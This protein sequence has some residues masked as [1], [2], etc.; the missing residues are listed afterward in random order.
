[1]KFI[2]HLNRRRYE[3][4]SVEVEAES[5][6]DAQAKADAMIAEENFEV[7]GNPVIR[8]LYFEPGDEPGDVELNDIFPVTD[9]RPY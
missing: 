3:H 7:M 8:S 6:E 4:A 1:M 5:A 2:I 9:N